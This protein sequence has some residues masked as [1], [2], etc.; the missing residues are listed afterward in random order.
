VLRPALCN[1]KTVSEVATLCISTTLF[2]GRAI[3]GRIEPW[4][5]VPGRQKA[6]GTNTT[7]ITLCGSFHLSCATFRVP[8]LCARTAYLQVS[9]IQSSESGTRMHLSPMSLLVCSRIFET[10]TS[11][12]FLADKRLRHGV[13]FLF[14][15]LF[16]IPR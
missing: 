3:I 4:A 10:D 6:V 8:R 11:L 1:L 14:P 12:L 2:I 5:A 7:S 13:L 9:R 15:L 16:K